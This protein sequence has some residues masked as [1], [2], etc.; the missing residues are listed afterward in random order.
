MVRESMDDV[1][2]MG[3]LKTGPTNLALEHEALWSGRELHAS[4]LQPTGPVVSVDRTT[5]TEGPHLAGWEKRR[6]NRAMDLT[7]TVVRTRTSHVRSATASGTVTTWF[8][9]LHTR[10]TPCGHIQDC[11]NI[12][13]APW[14]SGLGQREARRQR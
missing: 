2:C 13:L 6:P 14:T 10:F 7:E 1:M 12:L 3:C 11:S 8:H 5:R 4:L 9:E